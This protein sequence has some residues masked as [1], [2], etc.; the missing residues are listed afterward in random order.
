M[1][2]AQALFWIRDFFFPRCFLVRAQMLKSFFAAAVRPSARAWVRTTEFTRAARKAPNADGK[3]V[4]AAAAAAATQFVRKFSDVAAVTLNKARI[5]I[6]DGMTH[7][8]AGKF[9]ASEGLFRSVLGLLEGA[10][11]GHSRDQHI[12]QAATRLNLANALREQYKVRDLANLSCI[13][14]LI[15]IPSLYHFVG[16]LARW[17]LADD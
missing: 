5:G 11:T 8:S 10:D 6:Q 16:E 17:S 1:E 13:S 15:K 3:A 4:V 12:F 9:A 2:R 14:C 7:Y